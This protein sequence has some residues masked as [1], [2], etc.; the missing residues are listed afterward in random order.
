MAGS[1]S[2]DDVS[3][4]R[5]SAAAL[6]AALASPPLWEALSTR[7]QKSSWKLQVLILTE[8]ELQQKR[9]SH[10]FQELPRTEFHCL[11]LGTPLAGG[12]NLSH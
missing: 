12:Q 2:L 10:H 6:S 9:T 1:R 11:V 8:Q 3:Q 7:W 4:S 5:S